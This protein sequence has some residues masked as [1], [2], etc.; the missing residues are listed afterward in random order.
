[1]TQ[2]SGVVDSASDFGQYCDLKRFTPDENGIF[3]K[4]IYSK[5]MSLTK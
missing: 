5:L 3:S 1:M 2:V 4:D